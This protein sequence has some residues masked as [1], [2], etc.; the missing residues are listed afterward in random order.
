MKADAL[1]L[2]LES[3][4]IDIRGIAIEELESLADTTFGYAPDGDESVRNAGLVKWQDW[5]TGKLKS[6]LS[7]V[8]YKGKNFDKEIMARVDDEINFQWKDRPHKAMPDNQ[9]SVRWIGRI[10]IPKAG[11]YTLSVKAD[12]GARVWIGKEM[13]QIITVWSEYSYAAHTKKIYLEEGL[14]NVKIEYY[15][16]DKDATMK[17]FWDSDDMK[18]QVVPEKY[19]SHVS[20]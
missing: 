18:K 10:R 12:D 16:N 11:E 4:S 13:K 15:E 2:A 19:L 3:S 14:H 1:V 17:L 8:Y 6:G 5:L 20:L 9:F 7:G